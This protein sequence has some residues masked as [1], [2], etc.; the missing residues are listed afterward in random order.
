VVIAVYKEGAAPPDV[1]EEI[2]K[3]E[4]PDEIRGQQRA[5]QEQRLRSVT[6]A[7]QKQQHKGI[8]L[9]PQHPNDEDSNDDDGLEALNTKKRDRRTVADYEREKMEAAMTSKRSR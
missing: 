2:N 6:Q 4:L 3:G 7:E 5:I 9:V 1:L 8:P